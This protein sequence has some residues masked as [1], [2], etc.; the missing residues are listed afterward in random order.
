MATT[1]G[2]RPTRQVTAK[3][4]NDVY[5][6]LLLISFS[7]L[8]ISSIL[9]YLDYSQYG[10]SKAPKPPTAAA[11]SGQMMPGMG[12]VPGENTPP[13]PSDPKPNP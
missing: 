5:T 12:G 3:P 2:S 1:T 11:G 10:D 7:A 9:L 8:V 6:G 13:P 4:R